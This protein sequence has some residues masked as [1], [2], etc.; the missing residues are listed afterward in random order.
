MKQSKRYSEEVRECAVRMV[1]K[2]RPDY[3]S[4]WA[5]IGSTAGKI[6]CIA[7]TLQRKHACADCV[8]A[9]PSTSVNAPRRSS[10][11]IAS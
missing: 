9:R 4:Q 11:R 2:H 7:E 6:G 5:T 8:T 10:E 1:F 3:A